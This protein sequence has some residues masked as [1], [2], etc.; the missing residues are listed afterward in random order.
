[1][2][3]L[4][5]E[6]FTII[7]SLLPLSDKL[8]CIR[9]S[10]RWHEWITR[11]NLHVEIEFKGSLHKFHQGINF[12][13]DRKHMGKRVQHLSISQRYFDADDIL[14][15]PTLFPNVKTMEWTETVN[16]VYC[17]PSK[18]V[19]AKWKHLEKITYQP[20]YHPNMP[21]LFKYFTFPC[22]K[23]LEV[24]FGFNHNVSIVNSMVS[25]LLKDIYK[26][27]ILDSLILKRATIS[28]ENMEEIYDVLPKL[29]KVK[30]VQAYL[31]KEKSEI[32]I[33]APA[34][35]LESLYI[36]YYEAEEK[37]GELTNSV[38]TEAD[39]M[40]TLFHWISYIGKK[41]KNIQ[42]LNM[43]HCRENGNKSADYDRIEKT[44]ENTLCTFP[45]IKT[46]KIVC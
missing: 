4:P 32:A 14:L 8:N 41:F 46:Y 2:E 10:K 15:L 29:R 6:L 17:D 16:G 37:F 13:K 5:T 42:H 39:Y 3:N 26:A 36:E 18:Q 34:I 31:S 45:S 25:M 7:V 20:Q 19:A 23:Q 30:L 11:T 21:C 38:V 27:P 24:N 33:K 28:L 22:L 9:V 35:Q 1:M 40:H 43:L 12:F 44:I